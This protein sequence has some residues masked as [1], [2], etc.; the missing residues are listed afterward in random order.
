MPGVWYH[1]VETVYGAWIYGDERGFR[2]RHHR[3]HVDGDYKRPPA[4]NAH[5]SKRESNFNK[6]KQPP[7]VVDVKWRPIIATAIRE[8]LF[9][10]GA[11]VLCLS[12][13]GQHL[14]VLAK[15]PHELDAR[16]VIGLAK[17]HSTFIVKAKGWE[18]KLWGRRGKELRVRDREHQKNAYRYILDHMHEGAWV[19]DWRNPCSR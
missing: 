6:L 18:G 5:Q 14:H 11:F 9:E 17:K 3:E 12:Q 15:L 4:T 10:H 13:S 16:H 19:W 1:F 2:T 8:R 7:V